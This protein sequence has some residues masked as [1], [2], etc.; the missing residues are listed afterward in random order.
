MVF[1]LK[2]VFFLGVV[3]LLFLQGAFAAPDVVR[4]WS[5]FQEYNERLDKSEDIDKVNA[6][7]AAVSAFINEKCPP[8]YCKHILIVGDDFVIPMQRKVA[9]NENGQRQVIYSDDI[10]VPKSTRNPGETGAVFGNEQNK[11]VFVVPHSID[12]RFRQA[13]DSLKSGMSSKYGL[14]ASIF[15]EYTDSAV[16]CSVTSESIFWNKSVIVIG[17]NNSFLD[18][19]TFWKNSPN[20]FDMFPSPWGT[21]TIPKKNIL[22]IKTNNPEM[23]EDSV[24]ILDY[25]NTL[26]GSIVDSDGDGWSDKDELN[27]HTNPVDKHDNI[28]TK[29]PGMKTLYQDSNDVAYWV[30]MSNRLLNQQ[31]SVGIFGTQ[32]DSLISAKDMGSVYGMFMG[33][34]NGLRDDYQFFTVDL[35][36]LLGTIAVASLNTENQTAAIEFMGSYATDQLATQCSLVRHGV[37]IGDELT[38]IYFEQT[39]PDIYSQAERTQPIFDVI[40]DT[41]DRKEF[42]DSF[43]VYYH[44]GYIGEQIAVGKS[45]SEAVKG[46]KLGM[47]T[48]LK[49]LNPKALRIIGEFGELPTIKHAL[50]LSRITDAIDVGKWTSTERQGLHSLIGRIPDAEGD[51]VLLGMKRS[52]WNE[53]QLKE[54]SRMAAANSPNVG[55][56][57]VIPSSP[58][59][60]NA[61]FWVNLGGK[62]YWVEASE[63]EGALHSV[64]PV[65]DRLLDRAIKFQYAYLTDNTISIRLT[66]GSTVPMADIENRILSDY[67]TH[68]AELANIKRVQVYN[69][70]TGQIIEVNRL[71]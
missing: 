31:L 5:T 25:N 3:L 34:G 15:E 37:N 63:I 8:S 36:S 60:A 13:I 54:I 18:C 49:N 9:A 14:S 26:R 47:L 50:A 27:A 41:N 39:L 46:L 22:L 64:I 68:S 6:Y 58:T 17:G 29:L 12:S 70:V 35:L 48:K 10:Y 24:S 1:G 45:I 51:A 69:A 62:E 43:V 52:V 56:A 30:D 28:C 65:S 20:P 61:E 57:K 4:P 38:Q 21:Q 42:N 7:A 19:S 33:V 23:V 59:Q 71:G 44:I 53:N 11:I 16:N 40:H 67:L 55:Y 66:Q 32:S 2:R